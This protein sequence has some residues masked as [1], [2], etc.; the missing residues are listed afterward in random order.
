VNPKEASP[1]HV[2][3]LLREF[4]CWWNRSPDLLALAFFTGESG[5]PSI[6]GSKTKCLRCGFESFIFAWFEAFLG[7]RSVAVHHS[8][9]AL[10]AGCHREV[11][12]RLAARIISVFS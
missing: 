9:S 2:L 5:T 11:K 6:T 4:G 1:I 3:I 8:T 12:L 7:R 10:P